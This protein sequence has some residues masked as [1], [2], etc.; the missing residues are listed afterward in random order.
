MWTDGGVVTAKSAS[1]EIGIDIQLGLQRKL[2]VR[3]MVILV[4][5]DVGER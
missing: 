1:E 5:F 3:V 4:A 2:F